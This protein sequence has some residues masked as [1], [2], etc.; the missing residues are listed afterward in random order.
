MKESDTKTTQKP[1]I[2]QIMSLK[3]ASLETIQ[4]RYSALFGE[5]SP[6]SNNKAYLWRK[7]AFRLQEIE[8]GGLSP[9]T[10]NRISELIERYDPVNNKMLRPQNAPGKNKANGRDTRLPIPGAI[11]RKDYKGQ[12]LEVK[13]LEKGFEYQ[14]Q[15]YKTLSAVA[16][17]VTGDHWNGY[18][19]FKP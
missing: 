5:G 6:C 7:I 1:V 11:I 10:Q 12:V 14:G 18:L 8:Y 2:E 3:D 9:E 16:K 17:A 4:A 15:T 13:V 19:F